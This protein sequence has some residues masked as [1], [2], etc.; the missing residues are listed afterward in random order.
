[1]TDLATG[2]VIEDSANVLVTARGMLNDMSWPD[3]PG[4]STFQGKLMHSGDWDMK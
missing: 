2:E 4:L 1:M 3:I